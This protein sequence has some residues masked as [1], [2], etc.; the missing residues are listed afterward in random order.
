MVQYHHPIRPHTR[1]KSEQEYLRANWAP[2]FFKHSVQ[3]VLEC[4]SHMSKITWPVRPSNDRTEVGYDEGFVR[5][6]KGTVY[7]GEG[8]MGSSS[9]RCRRWK[10]LDTCSG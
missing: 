2:L 5:D 8:G 4:D 6:E 7:I 1:R 10:R 3:L 9:Q